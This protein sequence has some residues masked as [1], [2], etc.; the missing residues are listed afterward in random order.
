MGSIVR[1]A[2][3]FRKY[4]EEVGSQIGFGEQEL[5]SS[6]LSIQSV[7]ASMVLAL[8]SSMDWHRSYDVLVAFSSISSDLHARQSC[9]LPLA[10]CA[11]THFR[12]RTSIAVRPEHSTPPV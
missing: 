9:R 7:K 4:S 3:M 10:S 2:W 8:A 6:W 1:S 12:V 5:M 11:A